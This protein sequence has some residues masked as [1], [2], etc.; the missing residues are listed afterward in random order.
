MP[1]S[2]TVPP[3]FVPWLRYLAFLIGTSG[4]LCLLCLAL[5]DRKNRHVEGVYTN[6]L[7]HITRIAN[8]MGLER[9]ERWAL[10]E[11]VRHLEDDLKLQ[12]EKGRIRRISCWPNTTNDYYDLQDM[13]RSASHPPPFQVIWLDASKYPPLNLYIW[14]QDEER[15]EAFLTQHG[16][17]AESVEADITATGGSISQVDRPAGP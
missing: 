16:A 1:G 10:C 6:M 15:A 2:T 8:R 9:A 7:G 5:A 13:L 11:Y 17:C 3:R 12:I 4:L 14:A